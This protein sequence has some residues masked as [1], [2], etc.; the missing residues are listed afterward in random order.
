MPSGDDPDP[1]VLVSEDNDPRSSEDTNDMRLINAAKSSGAD[2]LP[3]GDIR[4][5][6]SKS[7]TRC[8]NCTHIEY[9]VS[10][11]EA[12]LA[13]SMSLIDHGANG[14]V[15]GDYVRIIFRTNC[16]VDIKGIDI[17]HVNNI[18]IG[19]VG[20]VV[21]T[22]HGP[23]IAIKHQYALLRKGAPIHSTS[24]LEWYK[25]DINDKSVL[26]PGGLQR[27]TTLEGYI[28]PLTIKD[29]LAPL[30]ICRHIDHE[31][32]TL[33]HEFLTLEMEWDPTALDHQYHDSSEWGDTSL[34][35]TGT[36][37]NAR[38]VEFKQYRQRV[39]V[40][41]LLYFS[42]QDGTT[43]EDNIDQCVLFPHSL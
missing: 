5:V 22:Q 23:V 32:D 33:P 26:V 12:I 9:F 1:D 8:V 19:T 10:K 14:G 25:N 35:S 13:H 18:G 27:I 2:H 4:R 42:Q 28:I 30:D 34:S 41:L 17:H 29:G 6:M 15:A 16:S 24:Q 3:P 31:F 21:Q 36:L 38:Y 40:N 39:L 20:G 43:L 37:N 7:S 11:H